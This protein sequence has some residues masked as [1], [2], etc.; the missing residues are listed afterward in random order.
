MPVELNYMS[1]IQSGV[2]TIGTLLLHENKAK[3]K[4]SH[5]IYISYLTMRLH[6]TQTTLLF[7]E[8]RLTNLSLR[9][10]TASAVSLAPHIL[11]HSAAISEVLTLKNFLAH[12]GLQQHDSEI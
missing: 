12:T 7:N 8:Y 1:E 10:T 2:G 5:Y 3:R 6:I 9:M 11:I 4:T